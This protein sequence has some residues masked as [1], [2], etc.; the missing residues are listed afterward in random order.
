LSDA[1]PG[2]DAPTAGRPWPLGASV[3]GGGVNFAVFSADASAVDLCLFDAEGRRELARCPLPA[4]SGDVWHGFVA[5]AGAGLVYGLRA[6]GR[7]APAEGLRFN[8]HKLL[9]DP[10]ARE[11]VGR[12]EWRDEHFGFDRADPARADAR[13]NAATALKA[14]VVD[15][16][17]DWQ[18]DAPLHHA[19]D[20]T[21]LYEVHVRSFTMR[22]PGVA[23]ALRGSYA[24]LASE[25]AVAHLQRLGITAVSL[26]PVHQHLDELH[27]VRRG[28]VNHWGYNTIGFFCP[29]PRL[30]AAGRVEPP[31]GRAV[32]DEFRA[33]VR[34]LHA[35]GIEVILDVV[36]NHTAETDENGPHLS[37]RG[38]DNRHWYRL[39]AHDRARYENHTGCGNTL[40]VSHPRVLQMVLD[41]LRHWVTEYHVDGFRFDLA[42]VL[43][44]GDAG[45]GRDGAFFK[46]VAQD[47]VLAGTKLVAE[48]WDIGPGGYRVGEFPPGW[49]E[50][51]DKFR[52]TMRAFWLGHACTRGEFARRLAG[53]ADLFRKGTRAPWAGVNYIVAHDGFTLR[54]LVSYNRRH[55]LANGEDGR[56]GHAHNLSCNFGHEGFSADPAVAQP[57]QRAERALLACTL[58]AQGTPM[59]AAGSELGA[60]QGGNNNAY[61][62]DNAT[63][64]LDWESADAALL[65]LACRVVALRR[66]LL[67]LDGR[68]YDGAPLDEGPPDLHWTQPDGSALS[69]AD[70]ET[71][72]RR[73][74]AVH[75]G[76]TGRAGAPLLLLVNAEAGDVEFRLPAG[77]W[78]VLLDTAGP[79]GERAASGHQPVA[80]RSVMLLHRG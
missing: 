61:C 77:P 64:W 58:L 2:F 20:D 27:L 33:M 63:T 13:D 72:D 37:W 39:D 10:W 5:G 9:L 75:V 66:R 14:R 68:W 74:L 49:A 30:A 40:A 57:R 19:W 54:D 28:L 47:P 41:S 51:N 53:S 48:P 71:T 65:R 50:W 18:G 73:A 31:D 4:R 11:I 56:D 24:G 35:A 45:F 52:D 29:E 23:P 70:W 42:P 1:A 43:A 76:R 34:R 22:H 32:R 67:P 79:E 60:S 55:N 21:V 46:A 16:A 25:A 59:L 78:H 38:L 69:S 3:R 15:D 36:Y 17:F 7:W 62:Q 44:R 8:P 12:F 80:A 26:L 6:H